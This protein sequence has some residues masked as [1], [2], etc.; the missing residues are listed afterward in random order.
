MVTSSD[1]HSP[2]SLQQPCNKNNV[3]CGML[4]VQTQDEGLAA[5]KVHR[6][7]NAPSTPRGQGIRRIP[8]DATGD[9]KRSQYIL[10]CVSVFPQWHLR[11]R[12]TPPP[13][14]KETGG[15]GTWRIT[16]ST[17]SANLPATHERTFTKSVPPVRASWRSHHMGR[18]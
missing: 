17:T 2:F 7:W 18:G 4:C 11:R 6:R 8:L 9:E 14:R 3:L 12:Q 15:Y 16:R 5:T 1:C 13:D 10:S